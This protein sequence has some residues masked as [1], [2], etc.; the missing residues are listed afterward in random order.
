[1]AAAKK[2]PAKKVTSRMIDPPGVETFVLRMGPHPDDGLTDKAARVSINK[3]LLAT[4]T[5]LAKLMS[6][7][8]GATTDIDTSLSTS[9]GKA[10]RAFL[11]SANRLNDAA[12]HR[13]PPPAPAA[14]PRPP[15]KK[16]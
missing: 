16:K 15:K 3:N 13:I 4:S 6:L 11:I 8:S 5:T 2:T 9:Q 7:V 14:A 10:L 1:M 12:Q